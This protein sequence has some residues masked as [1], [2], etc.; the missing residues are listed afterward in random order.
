MLFDLSPY[1]P[2]EAFAL[3]WMAGMAALIYYAERKGW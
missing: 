1:L 2:I 3:L